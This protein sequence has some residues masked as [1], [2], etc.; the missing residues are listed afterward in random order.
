MNRIIYALLVV[1]SLVSGCSGDAE[2][3]F[4]LAELPIMVILTQ[5]IF[6]VL[7]TK[8]KEHIFFI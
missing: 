3:D 8:T 6:F 4:A 5:R 7:D 2:L 1:I